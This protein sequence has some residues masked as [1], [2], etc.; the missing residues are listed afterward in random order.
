MFVSYI[1][2]RAIDWSG[3]FDL[4][5]FLAI[6]PDQDV[7]ATRKQLVWHQLVW[8]QYGLA[9][10]MSCVSVVCFPIRHLY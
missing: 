5:P 9:C 2:S 6:A 1:L 7:I 4:V 8:H 3:I 10:C